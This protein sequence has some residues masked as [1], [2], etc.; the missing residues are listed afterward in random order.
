MIYALG[1]LDMFDCLYDIEWVSITIYQPR[2][3]NISTW[4]I[5]VSAL[6]NWGV[7]TLVPTSHLA[8]KGD[9]KLC[10]GEHCQFCKV[11]VLCR[12]RAEMGLEAAIRDFALPP[13]LTDE[14]VAEMLPR[15]KDTIKWAEG[16]LA[17]AFSMAC[18][19]GKQ[20]P[21]YKLVTGRSSGR[22]FTDPVKA[23]EL[24]KAAGWTDIYTAPELLS[25]AQME[26]LMKAKVF[27][28]LLGELVV[29]PPGN[30]TLVP[31]SDKR[32]ALGG[33]SAKEDFS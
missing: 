8:Y 15:L 9:G 4:T 17:Y 12:A 6:R 26:K 11:K 25:V 18:D 16:L 2:R 28:E 7:Q 31:E 14:E 19:H 1:V 32:P 24:A 30:P 22:V 10:P 3:E 29:S 23:E 27:R 13:I 21:G 20:W 5:N 33:R